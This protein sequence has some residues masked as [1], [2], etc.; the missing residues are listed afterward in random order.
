MTE[1]V[2]NTGS[3]AWAPGLEHLDYV[4]FCPVPRRCMKKLMSTVE[5]MPLAHR[6]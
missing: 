4:N 2:V 3:E 1:L 5:D 6:A